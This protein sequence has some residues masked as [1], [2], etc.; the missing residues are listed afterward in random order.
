MNKFINKLV[1]IGVIQNAV[2]G[3]DFI[4]TEEFS[5]ELNVEIT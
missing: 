1:E 4:L 3:E 2:N 5:K